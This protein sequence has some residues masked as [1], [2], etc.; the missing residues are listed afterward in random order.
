MPAQPKSEPLLFGGPLQSS[1][2][3]VAAI[4]LFL[5][6]LPL[7]S[8]HG[9]AASPPT[10]RSE[11]ANK[12]AKDEKAL[13]LAD[14]IHETVVWVPVTVKLAS[15][16]DHTADMILTHYRPKGEGPF[17][18]VI[19]NHGRAPKEKR[20]EV[21]RH[22]QTG[23]A[24]YWT[25]RGFAVFVP[26]RLGYG[27]TSQRFDPESS[28]T[29]SAADYRPAVDAMVRHIAATIEFAR[30]QPW[31]DMSRIVLMGA[32]YGGFATIA[33]NGRNFPGLTAAINFSGG[34]GGNP[35]Q[36]PGRPCSPDRI[37]QVAAEAGKSAKVPMLW[38]YSENDKFWGAEWPLKWFA[39]YIKGGGRAE[40][41]M[42]PPVDDDGHK[43]FDKGFRLWRPVVD[44][45]MSALGFPEPRSKD[46][47]EASG[48]AG[49][50]E[51]S[52]LP[53]VKET[54]KSDGYQKFLD[55]DLPRAFAIAPTGNWAWRSAVGDAMEQA[56]ANCERVAK[57]ACK[58]YAVDDAVV[59]KP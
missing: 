41:K 7:E 34:M 6:T 31:S 9:E 59:W 45:F 23:L 19:V 15:G 2:A 46:A 16:R 24:R 12:E 49:L 28:G 13:K 43:L 22:R 39:A 27:E 54:A 30:E 51:A 48:F 57:Q 32:S 38:L 35:K 56:L 17:P 40:L 25:R 33:A 8:A 29:C 26:T 55:A 5:L 18:V 50:E 14:D 44:K 4:V 53:Y 58:L 21:P 47:P 37:A 3:V 1:A 20:A 42:F 36:R 11:A 10:V 52:K